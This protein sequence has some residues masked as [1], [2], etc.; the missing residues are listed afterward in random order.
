MNDKNF[1]LSIEEFEKMVIDL[2]KND[3]N[4]FEKVFLNQFKETMRYLQKEYSA[5]H[6][7]A[8]DATMDALIDFRKR[9]VE[10]KLQYGNLRFLF[11]KCAS[12][13]YFKNKKGNTNAELTQEIDRE[14][15]EEDGREE[16]ISWLGE[17]W[18]L[19]GVSCK[20]LLK[21]HYYGKMKLAEIAEQQE[22]PAAAIRKQKERCVKQLKELFRQKSEIL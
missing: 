4:F 14:M 13:V 5:L 3:T 2:K 8:Y 18:E 12:Q 22:K 15:E 16:E 20:E 21:W 19:L 17:A 7:D 10:G 6:E 1:G 9:F 11:T